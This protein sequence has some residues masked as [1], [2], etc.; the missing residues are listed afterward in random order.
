MAST[1]KWSPGGHVA[2]SACYEAALRGSVRMRVAMNDSACACPAP[3]ALVMHDRVTGLPGLCSA[4]GPSLW[5]SSATTR[6]R[7]LLVAISAHVSDPKGLLLLQRATCSVLSLHA[8]AAVLVVDNASPPPYAAQLRLLAEGGTRVHVCRSPRASGWAF[9]VLQQASEWVVRYGATHFAYLQHSMALRRPLPLAPLPHNCSLACYQHFPG[10]NFDSEERAKHWLLREWVVREWARLGGKY[11]KNSAFH[12]IY[13]HGFVAT[14]QALA[15]LAT[16]GLFQVR[17]CTKTQD[18]GSER[19]LGLAAESVVGDLQHL[20]TLDG[21]LFHPSR[22]EAHEQEALHVDKISHIRPSN[23]VWKAGTSTATYGTFNATQ[24]AAY[25]RARCP[26][27][28]L[29]LGGVTGEV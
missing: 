10:R 15:A 13:S 2:W 19:L 24:L 21:P 11:P 23:S 18:E 1:P 6:E 4:A 9:G 28:M 29:G 25:V 12:G 7:R 8:E 20:C 27:L 26:T 5:A 3:H 14:A 17:V 22:S 16:R